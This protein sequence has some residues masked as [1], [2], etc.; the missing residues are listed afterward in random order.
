MKGAR[1]RRRKCL[2]LLVALSAAMPEVRVP[3][4]APL[5]GQSLSVQGLVFESTAPNGIALSQL[6]VPRLAD[7][8]GAA[9]FCR[10][11]HRYLW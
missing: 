2:L 10:C 11:S 4:S 5:R 1:L 8:T 7:G 6:G 3:C 9:H